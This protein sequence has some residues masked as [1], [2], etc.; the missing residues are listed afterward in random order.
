MADDVQFVLKH[1]FDR[2]AAEDFIQESCMNSW[3]KAVALSRVQDETMPNDSRA[4][5][6][7]IAE[8]IDLGFKAAQ[9]RQDANGICEYCKL[10]F[11]LRSV[12]LSDEGIMGCGSDCEYYAA[13][14]PER[15]SS[16]GT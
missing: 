5:A 11:Q 2:R 14:S 8:Y 3:F 7:M 4:L 15:G 6:K 9:S 1:P 12:L 16:D 10:G 13:G